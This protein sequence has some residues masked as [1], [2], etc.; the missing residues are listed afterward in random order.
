MII[1]FSNYTDFKAAASG[2]GGIS[3]VMYLITSGGSVI[4]YVFFRDSDRRVDL[5]LGDG[6]TSGITSATILEDFPSAFAISATPNF[7]PA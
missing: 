5:L 1:T 3:L 7:F 6:N 2:F 4:I